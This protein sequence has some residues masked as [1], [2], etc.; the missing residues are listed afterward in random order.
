MLR[1]ICG[2]A[3]EQIV[4]STTTFADSCKEKKIV[5]STKPTMVADTAPSCCDGMMDV[6]LGS[7]EQSGP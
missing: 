4:T 2:K 6:R 5:N 7:G 3:E 1:C